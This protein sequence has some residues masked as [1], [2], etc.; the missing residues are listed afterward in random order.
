FIPA[1]DA[2]AL[3]RFDNPLYWLRGRL[4]EDGPPDQTTINRIYTNAVWADQW[5]KFTNSPLGTSTG[6]PSQ[7]FTFNQIPILPRQL[8]AVQ[9][10]G[11]PRA[12]TEWRSLAMQVVPDDPNIVTE[13]EALLAAEGPQT[14]I[15]LGNVHLVRDSTKSVIAV[16]IQWAEVQNFFESGPN[17]RVY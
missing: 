4:K 1:A 5:Q 15:V 3:A 16:W 17:D 8:I 2:K 6:V 7:I 12:N 9:E 11:G 13:L 14:D 10:L